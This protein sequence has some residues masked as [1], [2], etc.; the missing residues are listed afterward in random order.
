MNS[1]KQAILDT[2]IYIGHWEEGSYK[3][4]LLVCRKKYIIR[5]SSVILHELR[6][7][8]KTKY[9]I[10]LVKNLR[11]LS[12]IILT[13]TERNWWDAAEIVQSI[14]KKQGWERNKIR[15][16]QNDVLIAL[17]VYDN[18]ITIITNNRNDFKLIRS[19]LK[20]SLEIW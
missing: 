16:F 3:E 8:A 13:P 20:F 18:G 2:N 5:Q 6:R 4:R 17:T 7:Y 19:K 14:A 9:A 11:N 1:V 12:S 15:E 10:E